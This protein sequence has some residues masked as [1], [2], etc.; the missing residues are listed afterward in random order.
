MRLKAAH[1]LP[2][3]ADDADRAIVGSHEQA[4]G[5]RADARY[6]VAVEAL[7]GVVIGEGDGSDVEEVERL[8]LSLGKSNGQKD[9]GE[10]NVPRWPSC[11][12]EAALLA[13]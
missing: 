9:V 3:L 13:W 2:A 6:L 8:P 12:I 1:H 4:V 7:P 11:R 10:D 5:A